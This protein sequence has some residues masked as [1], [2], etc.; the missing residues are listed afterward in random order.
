MKKTKSVFNSIVN[1]FNFKNSAPINLTGLYDPVFLILI[2][3]LLG[4]GL[5]MLFSASFARAFYLNHGNSLHYISKQFINATIGLIGMFVIAKIDYRKYMNLAL[6]AYLLGVLVLV[7]VLIVGVPDK[8]G[9]KRWLYVGPIQFQPSELTKIALILLFSAMVSKNYKKMKLFHVGVV[10]FVAVLGVVL[11]LMFLEPH[12]SGAVVICSIA[13]VMMFVGGTRIR[14]F[15]LIFTLA[16]CALLYILLFKGNYMSGRAYFWLHPFSDPQNQ[17]MQTDQSLLAIGSGGFFGLGL[18]QSR[19]KFLFLPEVQNDFIF[20][21]ICEELGA[22]GAF[23]VIGLFL[24][25]CYKGFEIATRTN[26]KFGCMLCTGIVSQFVIQ[27]IYN[28]AVVTSTIPNTGISLPFF[29]YGGTAI[30]VQLWELGIV[31]NISKH[32]NT[33]KLLKLKI[34]AKKTRLLPN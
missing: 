31:L 11:I 21:V 18:G 17:T 22:I 19:Q 25:F 34:P 29:S 15:V 9:I 4:F 5:V 8:H 33:P 16:L 24:C 20:A 26:D 10:R 14:W 6:P 23:A 1:I 28:I 12:L 2:L 3:S 7:L 32:A 13:G 30:V 27:A